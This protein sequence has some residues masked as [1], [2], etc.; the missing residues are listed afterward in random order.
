[1]SSY[2]ETD[3]INEWSK[4]WKLDFNAKKCH[5]ME[6]GKSKR[7]PKWNYKMGQQEILKTKE[8]KDLGVVIQDILSPEQHINQIFGS[9]YRTLTNIGVAFHYMDKDMMKNILTSMIHLRLE[10]AAVLWSSNAK[11]DLRKLERILSVAT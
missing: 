5:V 11:K 8:E 6:L 7:R 4:R 2:K 1:M 3:K 10:Y 9:T